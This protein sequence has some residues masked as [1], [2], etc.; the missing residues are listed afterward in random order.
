MFT[1]FSFEIFWTVRIWNYILLCVS[2]S[3]SVELEHC[4]LFPSNSPNNSAMNCIIVRN[5]LFSKH[6]AFIAFISLYFSLSPYSVSQ[7]D[8]KI[9]LSLFHFAY[10]LKKHSI[11][12]LRIPRLVISLRKKIFFG[13]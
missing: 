8:S 4:C 6:S 1:G 7:S 11:R 2:L 12:N 10:C 9:L 3:R 13:A 5:K